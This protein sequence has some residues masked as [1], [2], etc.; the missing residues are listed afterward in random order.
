[1]FHPALIAWSTSYSIFLHHES[2]ACGW[3]TGHEATWHNKTSDMHICDPEF[4]IVSLSLSTGP[5]YG[6][7]AITIVAIVINLLIITV[8]ARCL[9][10]RSCTVLSNDCLVWHAILYSMRNPIRGFLG[11][12]KLCQCGDLGHGIWCCRTAAH[13]FVNGPDLSFVE[14]SLPQGFDRGRRRCRSS[15][16]SCRAHSSARCVGLR[17]TSCILDVVAGKLCGC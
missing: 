3:F 14:A 1:M 16:L 17:L 13:H 9:L 5:A 15:R 8:V 11:A 10:L 2:S 7:V 4:V 12:I 6:L